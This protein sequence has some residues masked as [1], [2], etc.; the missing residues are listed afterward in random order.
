MDKEYKCHNSCFEKHGLSNRPR[1]TP[2]IKIAQESIASG[3]FILSRTLLSPILGYTVASHYASNAYCRI[4]PYGEHDSV[5]A[6]RFLQDMAI[7]YSMRNFKKSDEIRKTL[8]ESMNYDVKT[9]RENHE[10]KAN[11]KRSYYMPHQTN[12][13]TF[14]TSR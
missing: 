5:K 12:Q 13:I 3:I 1:Y 6:Y 7:A 2:F 8:C 4:S 10:M 11:N 14:R 9:T